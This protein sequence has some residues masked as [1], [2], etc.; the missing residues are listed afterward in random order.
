VTNFALIDSFI[1]AKRLENR[2][3]AR[4]EDAYRPVLAL[5]L[6]QLDKPAAQASKR[7]VQRFLAQYAKPS[8]RAHRHAIIKSFYKWMTYED[9]VPYN[10]A[11]QVPPVRFPR[12]NVVRLTRSEILRLLDAAQPVRRDRWAVGLMLYGGLRNSELRGLRGRDLMRDGWVHVVEGKGKKERWIPVTAELEPIVSEVLQLTAPD[13][14]VLPGRRWA[15]PAAA[16]QVEKG[17]VMLSS[18]ALR[19]QVMRVAD[20]AGLSSHVTP[21][22]LRHGFA[23]QAV[24]LAGV[25]LASQLL[26]H[27]DVGTT[28]NTYTGAASLDEL[29]VS[30]AGFGYRGLPVKEREA[31]RQ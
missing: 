6:E 8:T 17:A 26:G 4:S 29:A 2:M 18:S 19:K 21:H 7:D 24:R 25:K 28:V 13:L 15:D 23:E 22:T 11:D 10:V 31:D 14:F 3:S 20:R 5:F 30:M 12:A 27:A 1:D 9:L 16:V